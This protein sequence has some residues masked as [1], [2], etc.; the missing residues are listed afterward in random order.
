MKYL[1]IVFIIIA[2]ISCESAKKPYIKNQGQAH[3]TFYHITYESPK[4]KDLHELLKQSMARIDKS[5]STYDPISVISRINQNDSS[6][7]LDDHFMNVYNKAYEIA[8]ETHGAFDMTVAPL[9]NAW[10]FGFT[11]PQRTDNRS[12]EKILSY[13]GYEK[14]KIIDGKIH[15]D[16]STMQLDASA[17]A[18]G[19]SVDMAALVLEK[20]G[21]VNYMVEIGGEI[22][23]KGVNEQGNPWRIGIDEPSDEQSPSERKLQK[24][25][26]ISD[27]AMATSGNYRQFYIKD[28]KKYAHT[29]NPKT[30]YPIQH[31]LLSAS[32]IAPDCMTADAY[33]TAFMVLGYHASNDIVEQHPE[34]E[35]YF[36]LSGDDENPY[37]VE[38]S[39]GM[40]KYF[41]QGELQ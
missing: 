37:M 28:G 9:V 35:A 26:H 25:I 39:K 36:I 1:S 24:V 15:K 40:K 6:V 11:E 16:T 31:S 3:G 22:R 30:G 20:H 8:K 18:K 38:Y 34:L 29:I 23:V 19:Y 41:K 2:F 10:G 4:N 33:A 21:V 13:T 27:A 17:I 5:L 32:V 14:I 7:V 12:I